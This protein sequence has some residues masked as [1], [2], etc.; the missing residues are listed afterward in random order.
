MNLDTAELLV[1]KNINM[2]NRKINMVSESNNYFI[3]DIAMIDNAGEKRNTF[4]PPIGVNK[5]TG[6][7]VYVNP[8]IF[9]KEELRSVERIR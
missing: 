7:L 2:H 1:R 9:S 8:A 3:F 6:K 4:I 5:N